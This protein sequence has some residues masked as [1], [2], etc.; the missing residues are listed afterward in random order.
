MNTQELTS[1]TSAIINE[2][3]PELVWRIDKLLHNSFQYPINTE[4][5]N[6]VEKH[7]R[8]TRRC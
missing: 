5:K 8:K 3:P 2:L 7:S 4:I 1:T 6:T